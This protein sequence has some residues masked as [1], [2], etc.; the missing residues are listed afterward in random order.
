[1]RRFLLL[2]GCRWATAG[3]IGLAL[4][5][6][7][8]VEASASAIRIGTPF[9]IHA[10]Q[11]S[12]R[13]LVLSGAMEVKIAV[14]AWGC[15]IALSIKDPARIQRRLKIHQAEVIQLGSLKQGSHPLTISVR[16]RN[17]HC[18]LAAADITV[19]TTPEAAPLRPAPKLGSGNPLAILPFFVSPTTPAASAEAA[20]RQAG[21]VIDA[22]LLGRIAGRAQAVWLTGSS[23][24]TTTVSQTILAARTA[25]QLPVFVLYNIPQRGCSLTSGAIDGQAYQQWIASIA[26]KLG[27]WP[28]AV[29]LEPDALAE[30]SCWSS[31]QQT[32]LLQLLAHAVTTLAARPETMVYLD[33]GNSSWQT[34]SVMA[35]RLRQ[36]GIAQARGFALNTSNFQTTANSISYGDAISALVGAKHYVIDTSRNGQGPLIDAGGQEWCNPAGRGLGTAPTTATVDPLAE[37]YLWINDPGNSDGTCNGGPDAGVFWPSYA[38]SLAATS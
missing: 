31:V 6:A 12:R 1:M 13:P 38:L 9:V 29:I 33:A 24:D 35:A 4:F 8:T 7:S 22:N 19:Q 11:P 27:S 21:D 23:W 5:A 26:A 17:P 3:V 36:A 18:V 28:A 37:A 30:L 2:A 16:D 10:G 32:I 20:D 34:A 14:N 25:D 15:P